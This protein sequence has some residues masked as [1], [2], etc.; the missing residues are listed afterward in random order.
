MFCLD[1]EPMV[2]RL[3]HVVLRLVHASAI[4]R[5]GHASD[6]ETLLNHQALGPTTQSF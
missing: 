2:L 4:L 5:F 3:E 6:M 1:H